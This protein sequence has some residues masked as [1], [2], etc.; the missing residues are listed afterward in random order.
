MTSPPT[1]GSSVT[2][3]KSSKA[4]QSNL[5]SID[6]ENATNTPV[7]PPV[8]NTK[9]G[10]QTL[11]HDPKKS[12]YC[13]DSCMHD[14]R[15]K[16]KPMLRCILCICWFHNEC[17]QEK[18]DYEGAWCCFQ[19]RNIPQTLFALQQQF[20]HIQSMLHTKINECSQIGR[21]SC[22]ERV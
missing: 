18:L 13:T 6:V 11:S 9:M 2:D 22:R 20:A 17:V 8:C 7:L 14:R 15:H 19:C 1:H 10:V 4:N 21:A 16:D 12:P 3:T 5:L